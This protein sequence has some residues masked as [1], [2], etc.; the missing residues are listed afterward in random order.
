MDQ[1]FPSFITTDEFSMPCDYDLAVFFQFCKI[2]VS[3]VLKT[4]HEIGDMRVTQ[5]FR[6]VAFGMNK[7]KRICQIAGQERARGRLRNLRSGCLKESF[8]D[9][10]R[11][12][13]KTV[14]Y[15]VVP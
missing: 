3:A 1:E 9:S 12:S 5:R 4:D 11:L 14:L 7:I 13:S 10:V 6:V 8:S 15:E 2:S